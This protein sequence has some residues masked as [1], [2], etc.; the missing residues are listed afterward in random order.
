MYILQVHGIIVSFACM[1]YMLILTQE[2][3]KILAEVS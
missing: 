2:I 3:E 1:D